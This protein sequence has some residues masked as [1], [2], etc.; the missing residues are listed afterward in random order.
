MPPKYVYK[1]TPDAVFGEFCRRR[2]Q[3]DIA[4]FSPPKKAAFC[5][6]HVADINV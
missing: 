3:L 2:L 1:A 4:H 6:F 5:Y